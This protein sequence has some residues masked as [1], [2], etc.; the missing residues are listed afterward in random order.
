MSATNKVLVAGASG[1][2][3]VAA[4][5]KFIS[6]GRLLQRAT[7]GPKRASDSVRSPPLPQLS[8]CLWGRCKSAGGRVDA[9]IFLHPWIGCGMA[10]LVVRGSS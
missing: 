8:P 4:I 5:E 7:L 10:S 9:A 6:S 1:L 2:L 3:G